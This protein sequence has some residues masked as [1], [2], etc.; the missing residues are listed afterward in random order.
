VLDAYHFRSQAVLYFELAE[1]MSL[2]GDAEYCRIIAAR[3]LARAAE[4]ETHGESATAL[5]DIPSSPMP[6]GS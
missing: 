2:R 6:N 4:L 5:R 1:R 3:C